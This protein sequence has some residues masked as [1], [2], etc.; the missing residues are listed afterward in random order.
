MHIVTSV[1]ARIKKSIR[2]SHG[3]RHIIAPTSSIFHA[4]V[5]HADNVFEIYDIINREANSRFSA[6]GRG[7]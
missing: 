6:D 4:L 3:N 1:E 7:P 5:Y 2:S